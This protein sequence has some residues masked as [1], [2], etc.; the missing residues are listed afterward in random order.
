MAERNGFLKLKKRMHVIDTPRMGICDTGYHLLDP[1]RSAPMREAI[2]QSLMA[3]SHRILE[4]S[5]DWLV[6]TSLAPCH[7]LC[8]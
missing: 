5:K 2:S 8:V 4:K 6:V 1:L 3:S 7:L